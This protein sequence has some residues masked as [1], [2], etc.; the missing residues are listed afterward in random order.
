MLVRLVD[1]CIINEEPLFWH[2]AQGF[3]EQTC[4]SEV[5]IRMIE[6]IIS[7]A[8][9]TFTAQPERDFIINL[10]ITGEG[11]R[12]IVIDHAGSVETSPMSFADYF[13]TVSFLRLVMGLAFLPDICLGV[14]AT[15]DPALA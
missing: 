15:L 3:I 7:K 14:D 6:T 11:F 1:N 12:V 13:G 9:L 2:D 5:P 4:E 10:C 8:Y